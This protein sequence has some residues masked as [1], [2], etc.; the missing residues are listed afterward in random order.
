MLEAAACP[1][2]RSSWFSLEVPDM[3]MLLYPPAK[4][5]P[6][7]GSA[8]LSVA[9]H[10]ALIS[11]AVYATGV[12]SQ[13]VDQ[14]IRERVSFIRYLPPPDRVRSTEGAGE[15]LRYV[16]QGGGGVP[17]PTR[18]DGQVHRAA[19]LAG[20]LLNGGALGTDVRDQAPVKEVV[21]P[22]SVYSILD[23]E[24]AATRTVGSAAPIYP[25]DMLRD[26]TE[27]SVMVRFIVDT[28]G[29]A[30]SLSILVLSSTHQ[31]F[32]QS[33]RHAVPLMTFS[34]AMASGHKVR[35]LVEQRFG[36]RLGPG[37]PPVSTTKPVP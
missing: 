26:G 19:G 16:L 11:A 24:A 31:S 2:F 6:F 7:G 32:S 9:T 12:R 5:S 27:G 21:S 8:L 30:D 17:L 33:V 29:Q 20:P 37:D 1:I 22:D 14:A 35:Q 18:D 25:S 23:V 10:V 3:R 34:S 13:E 28:L 36:F 4:A 15:V